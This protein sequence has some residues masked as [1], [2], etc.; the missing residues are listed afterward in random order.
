MKKTTRFFSALIILCLSAGLTLQASPIKDP[1]APSDPSVRESIVRSLDQDAPISRG[2]IAPAANANQAT[3]IV[4]DEK[5]NIVSIQ[6]VDTFNI[7]FINNSFL[8]EESWRPDTY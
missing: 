5:G 4:T 7:P 6:T 1:D 2:A 8:T 3:V